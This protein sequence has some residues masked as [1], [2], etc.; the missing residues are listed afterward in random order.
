MCRPWRR[1]RGLLGG[2]LKKLKDG[3]RASAD[4]QKN[5]AKHRTKLEAY[6]KFCKKL[7]EQPADVGLAWLLHNK[8]VTAPIIGPRTVGQLGGSLRALDIKFDAA[9]LKKLDEIFPG[10]GGAAPEAYAW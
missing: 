3:R 8:A 7:G 10:P 9:A 1:G 4:M 6:E 5:V 2:V